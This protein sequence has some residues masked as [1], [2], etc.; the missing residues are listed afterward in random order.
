MIVYCH[1]NR[2]SIIDNLN[3]REYTGNRLLAP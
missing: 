3:Q 1:I 2:L